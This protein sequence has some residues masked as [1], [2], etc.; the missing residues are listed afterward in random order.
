MKNNLPKPAQLTP[1]QKKEQMVR[2]I[3]TKREQYTVSILNALAQNPS[4]LPENLVQRSV[5]MAD[6]LLEELFGIPPD[7]AEE[8]DGAS[9]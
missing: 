8:E 6:E 9:R 2:F 1:E 3:A 7:K 4:V 5:K